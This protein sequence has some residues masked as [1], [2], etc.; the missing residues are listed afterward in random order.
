MQQS[1][2]DVFVRDKTA[3]L[4]LHDVSPAFEDDVVK[5]CDRLSDLG[6]ESFTLLVTPFY[7]MKMSNSLE[8][9]G[10]FSKYLQ[11][12][13][14][15]L[16]LHGYSHLS[17][18]GTGDEFSRIALDRAMV[19]LRSGFNAIEK[20]LKLKPSGFVPPL[21]QAPLKMVDAAREVGFS[22]CVIGNKLYSFADSRAFTTARCLISEGSANTSFVDS[23]VELELG[24]AV[25]V[26]VHPLDYRVNKVFELLVDMKDRLGYR[27]VGYLDY[28]RSVS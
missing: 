27:F 24:G 11:S 6:L 7:G 10:I 2:T 28:L 1:K 19:R 12:L 26:G 9:N 14:L 21:W 20:T 4:S 3:L 5:S 8:K 15:E 22:Y 13:G 23:V 17:K 18:S 16:S 25:Q